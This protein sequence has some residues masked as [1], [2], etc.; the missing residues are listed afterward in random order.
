MH[1]SSDTAFLFDYGAQQRVL[2]V[3]VGISMLF[4]GAVLSSF[5]GLHEGKPTQA[6]VKALTAKLA[7]S[8]PAPVAPAAEVPPPPPPPQITK[9]QPSVPT[10]A[11]PTPAA[12]KAQA[13]PAAPSEVTAPI[14]PPTPQPVPAAPSA[15]SQQ[16]A[17][18]PTAPELNVRPLDAEEAGSRDQYRLALITAARRY[19]RYPA[20]AMQNGW[21]GR[22]EI[23][24]NIGANGM[25]QSAAIKTSTGYALLDE[26]ALDMIKKA[27]PL[28]V[29]FDLTAG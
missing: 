5:S 9:T 7:P 17:I 4:H 16:A 29:I 18:A 8:R 23:R 25:I 24:L 14:A 11:K 2:W 13:A 15:P 10:P 20:Q 6:P 22:V 1:A 21:T 27:K 19:K 26:T 3:C 12:P 28:P